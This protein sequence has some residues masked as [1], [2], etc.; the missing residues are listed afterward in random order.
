MIAK[1]LIMAVGFM[2]QALF[3]SRTFIQLFQTE[4]EKKVANPLIFWELSIVASLLMMA[5]GILRSDIIIFAGQVLN[6][7]VYIRNISLKRAWRHSTFKAISYVIPWLIFS[8]LFLT[9]SNYS[10]SEMMR[11]QAS[12]GAIMTL[13]WIGQAV[14]SS[15]F[16]YQWYYAEKKRES[17]FPLGFW[18][19]SVA[20]GIIL[21]V[22]AILRKDLVLLLGQLLGIAI[23]FRNIYYNRKNL[24]D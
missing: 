9:K 19:L 20:G 8:W 5:Y 16:F 1:L 22:Y 4:K 7:V 23:Y 2:S 14:F 12:F 24:K 15:R 3:A 21:C 17:F 18:L 10:W 13:G 11:V 6:Y